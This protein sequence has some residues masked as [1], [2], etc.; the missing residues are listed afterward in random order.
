MMTEVNQQEVVEMEPN[1]IIEVYNQIKEWKDKEH[2]EVSKLTLFAFTIRLISIIE[3]YL[4]DRDGKY[5]KNILKE[6]LRQL[7]ENNVKDKDEK[8]ILI[9]M[10]DSVIDTGIDLIIGVS[11]GEIDIGKY[12]NS[13][14]LGLCFY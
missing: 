12:K 8:F 6:V 2:K 11:K 10:L 14:I 7:I 3:L 4:K 5:K 13:C 9:E 1:D